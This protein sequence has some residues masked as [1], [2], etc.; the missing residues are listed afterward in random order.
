MGDESTFYLGRI[1][2]PKQGKVTADPYLYDPTD[3]TTHAVITGMTGS[4]KTG[5]C[6]S[7]LE[8]AALKGIPAIAVDPKGDLTNLLLHFPDLLPADFQPWIDP[9]T[10]RREGKTVDVLAQE[11]AASWKKGLADYGLGKEQLEKLK[12]SVEFTVYTPGSSSGVP[13]NILASFQSPDVPWPGNEEILREK[14]ASIVTALLGLVGVTDIDPLRSREHILI[15]NLLETAWSKGQTLQLSDLIL[16]VQNPPFERLG[17]LPVDGFFPEKDRMGLSMLLNNFMASPSFQIWLSGQTLDIQKILYKED[18]SPRHSIFYIAHLS[19]SERMFF[20]TMLYS[21]IESWMRTQRGT[22]SLRALVYFDEIMGYLPP[23]A[24]PPSRTVILRML[25]QARA[26]GVGLVLATQNPVDLDYKALSNAGTWVIG[27]LQ[28]EQD[29]NRLL[30]GLTSAAGS[31]DRSEVDRTISALGKRIFLVQ[32]VHAKGPV[33]IGTR[34]CLNY[35][36][37]PLA[38]TQIPA[39]NALAGVKPT[40]EMSAEKTSRG[41]AFP[42]AGETAAGVFAVQAA[43]TGE[44]RTTTRPGVPQGMDEVFFPNDLSFSQ[45]SEQASV[46]GAQSGLVYRPALLAQLQ[47]N[48]LSRSMNIDSS[49]RMTCLVEEEVSGRINWEDFA[50][51]EQD[52]KSLKA[53]REPGNALYTALPGW[54]TETKR[55]SQMQSDFE[56]WAYRTG[57]LSVM[58]NKSLKTTAAPGMTKEAFLETCRKAADDAA[59]DELEKIERDYAVK[60][61]TIDAKIKKQQVEISQKES[62]LSARRT[63]EIVKGASVVGNVLFGILGGKKSGLNSAL[64]GGSST[65]NKHRM[66]EEAAARVEQEKQDMAV[67]EGQ[68]SALEN[69]KAD[70][71]AAVREKWQKVAEDIQEVSIAP[72]KKDIY[73][74]LFGIVWLP[75]YVVK[76]GLQD[77]FIPGFKK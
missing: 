7:L 18:G 75:Y 23:V 72:A 13:V 51:K 46:S 28:T 10:A 76:A 34:W 59:K 44:T 53:Q 24:N 55:L 21:S 42:V 26:F 38:R 27:R 17:A 5:F 41:A 68:K 69:N 4:G 52:I 3:L 9:D 36:A 74:E 20:V 11:T 8:E 6:I 35:L 56:D 39:V 45:A 71:L 16:Q 37:G 66:A 70:E 12:N 49:K 64:S 60:A 30:D 2:D 31:I 47:V 1:F 43:N 32:N 19:E 33:L 40:A 61:S 58:S 29:K 77:R 22:S 54:L 25:K 65:L 50:F 48:Y 14:I 57:T 62:Q 15:S 63:D 67:L 73:T